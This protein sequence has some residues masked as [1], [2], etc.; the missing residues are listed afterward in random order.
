M[1]PS[2]YDRLTEIL[3]GLY[4]PITA[5]LS[6]EEDEDSPEQASR[7]KKAFDKAKRHV[8]K[9]GGKMTPDRLRDKPIR[10][11]IEVSAKGYSVK[12][13][14]YIRDLS[15]SKQQ[16]LRQDLHIFAGFKTYHHLSEVS[17]HARKADGSLKT[18]QEFRDD[19][20]KI[21]EKY[22]K[23]WL[24]SEY[25]F[26]QASA[27]MAQKWERFEK[28]GDAYDLL[29]KTAGD[30]R[31]RADHARLEGMCLP[32]SDPA[33]DVCYPPNGWG[34]RCDVIQVIPGSHP[35]ADSDEMIEALEEMTEGKQ[36]IFRFNAG[37]QGRLTPPKHPYY[38]KKGYGHCTTKQGKL[39]G[40]L[41]PDEE[42]EVLRNLQ[43][44]IVDRSYLDK[45]PKVYRQAMELVDKLCGKDPTRTQTDPVLLDTLQ[46]SIGEQLQKKHNINLKSMENGLGI[47]ISEEQV[48]H[49]I[50]DAKKDKGKAL[51]TEEFLSIK[52]VVQNGRIYYQKHKGKDTLV[53]A[54]KLYKQEKWAKWCFQIGYKKHGIH[55]LFVTAGTIDE[56]NLPDERL[57]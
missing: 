31:V 4:A 26:V 18:W 33:W 5:Q 27:Q 46:D 44:K 13:E 24:K 40:N 54:K 34:C 3:E 10:K 32:F 51:S 52:E 2:R 57:R 53:F 23:K 35:R 25:A 19:T 28:W 16:A 37:K 50:R 15:T 36:E 42:C 22:N 12:V 30:E 47:Y 8:L 11:A 45:L 17:Q 43:K 7:L 48:K 49:G 14:P 56:K 9:I 55:T 41:E 39:A 38:G 29:Y 20:D 21:D 6:G 1:S